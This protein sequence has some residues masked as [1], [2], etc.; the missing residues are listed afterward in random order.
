MA[1]ELI[2]E[3]G[4]RTSSIKIAQIN[5]AKRRDSCNNLM[6]ICENLKIE[7]ICIQEPPTRQKLVMGFPKRAGVIT[8]TIETPKSGI[9]NLNRN[10]RALLTHELSNDNVTAVHY[11]TRFGNFHL[12][13]CY[14]PPHENNITTASFIQNLTEILQKINTSTDP[15]IIAGDLNA[16]SPLWGSPYENGRGRAFAEFIEQHNLIVLNNNTTPTFHGHRGT[17]FIDVTM[18][19]AAGYRVIK[20]WKLTD[21]ET[22]SD[23]SLIMWEIDFNQ[24]QT[25]ATETTNRFNTKKANWQQFEHNLTRRLTEITHSMRDLPLLTHEHTNTLAQ[26]LCRRHAVQDTYLHPYNAV[27][28]IAYLRNMIS[29]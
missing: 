19:N 20:N 13:S 4:E 16:K 3:S 22:L 11:T 27:L 18:T 25:R 17:S 7:I 5:V 6:H 29:K 12:I 1:D 28:V 14:L 9:I 10:N 21:E 26:N 2:N 8:R 24:T 15:I 23:H